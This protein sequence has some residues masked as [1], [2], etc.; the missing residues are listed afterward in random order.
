MWK[1]SAREGCYALP[2]NISLRHAYRSREQEVLA[3][4]DM[5]IGGDGRV[6]NRPFGLASFSIQGRADKIGRLSI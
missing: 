3:V 2:E 4:P 5:R 1:S 6:P